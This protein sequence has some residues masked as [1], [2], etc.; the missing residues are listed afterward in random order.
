MLAKQWWRMWQYHDKLLNRVVQ[1]RYFPT[2]N[3]FQAS[4]GYRPSFTWQSVM[5]AQYLFMQDVGGELVQVA[6]FA[7]QFLDSFLHQAAASSSLRDA[8]TYSTWQDLSLNLVKIN[9][10]GVVFGREGEMGIGVVARNSQGQCL[11][12]MAHRVP[13]A[14]MGSWQ[15]LGLLG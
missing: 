4:L 6:T 10:D 5:V 14:G 3:I 13:H 7:T 1:A 9:F 8:G 15:R 2:G 11:A 12:W